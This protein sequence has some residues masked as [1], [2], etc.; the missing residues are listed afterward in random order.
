MT[1]TWAGTESSWRRRSS[2]SAAPAAAGGAVGNE[3]ATGWGATPGPA[4]GGEDIIR[5]GSEFAVEVD[6][7]GAAGMV[8]GVGGGAGGA[9][10]SSSSESAIIDRRRRRCRCGWLDAS[11]VSP[12]TRNS[13]SDCG[14]SCSC[15]GCTCGGG[16]DCGLD[17][18]GTGNCCCFGPGGIFR[19]TFDCGSTS[20]CI[21]RTAL[22]VRLRPRTG[23]GDREEL[24]L[25]AGPSEDLL[26]WRGCSGFSGV[27]PGGAC[28]GAG[29][30]YEVDV[31]SPCHL[32]EPPPDDLCRFLSSGGSDGERGAQSFVCGVATAGSPVALTRVPSDHGDGGV[33]ERLACSEGSLT[34]DGDQ[35]RF[36]GCL[37]A[38]GAR[39]R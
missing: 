19:C 8:A 4:V 37:L 32:T 16:C 6:I 9:G 25:R 3:P 12:G 38:D 35:E 34:T 21:G 27:G 2:G 11:S 17:C 5:A 14:C 22:E 18:S 1:G 13:G 15:G 30:L 26:F 39:P 36:A 24:L 31:P 33:H 23:A 28:W 7:A 10:S 20:A 29:V